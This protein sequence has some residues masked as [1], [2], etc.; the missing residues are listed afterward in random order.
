MNNTTEL[1]LPLPIH[2]DC[3]QFDLQSILRE[4]EKRTEIQRKW[5]KQK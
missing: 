4:K 5:K 3:R 1:I 2:P